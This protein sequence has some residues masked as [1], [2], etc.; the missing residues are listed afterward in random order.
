[1]FL[2]T[3]EHNCCYFLIKDVFQHSKRTVSRHFHVVLYALAAF[4]KE[5]IKT[6][7]CDE[8]LH[9]QSTQEYEVLSMLQGLCQ[10]NWQD[11]HY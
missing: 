6:H 3:I 7:S 5:M 4:P 1:M 10:C 2:L 11:T 8:T 9:L